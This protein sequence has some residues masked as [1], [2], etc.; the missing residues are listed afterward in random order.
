MLMTEILERVHEGVALKRSEKYQEALELYNGI[1]D[2]VE[3]E[4]GD[5]GATPLSVKYAV[6]EVWRAMA[7]IGYIMEHMGK[8]VPMTIYAIQF[9]SMVLNSAERGDIGDFS[10]YGLGQEDVIGMANRFQTE[11][12]VFLARCS[13]KYRNSSQY[14]AFHTSLIT[15][16]TLPFTEAQFNDLYTKGMQYYTAVVESGGDVPEGVF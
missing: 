15:R 6:G 7:K 16:V 5:L 4:Y 12:I 1:L 11:A 8:A 2:D 13:K 9:H 14:K 10:D 3:T